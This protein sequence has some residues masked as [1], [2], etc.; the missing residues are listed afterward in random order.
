M[1]TRQ[2]VLVAIDRAT[3]VER[4]TE[5][6]LM[7]AGAPAADVH[8]ISV[9]PDRTAPASERTRGGTWEH[10]DRDAGVEARLASLA[11]S[12]GHDGARIRRVTLHGAP[13]EVIP[14]YARIHDAALLVLERDYGSSPFWRNGR[15][16]DDVARRSPVPLLVLPE[17]GVRDEHWPRR[18]L[19]PV[20]FSIASAMALRRGVELARR[21]GAGV[22]VLHALRDVARH[23]VSSGSEAWDAVR[24]LP[25]QREVVAERLRRKAALFGAVDVRTEVATG[26]APRAIVDTAT[27]SDADLIVMGVA[28]RSWLDR[29]LFGTTLRQV[30][31]RA[32]VPVL[33]VPVLA[34]AHAWPDELAYQVSSGGPT[35]GSIPV[36]P[37]HFSLR[38]AFNL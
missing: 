8:V 24:R 30:L 4:A 19:A 16:V 17:H 14:A 6:A 23:V 37:A 32:T 3:D 34:G 9:A 21:H 28:H 36:R 35:A 33:V 26:A 7:T 2:L 1:A 29:A 15:V 11:R 31:R 20:D 18:I 13:E 5:F 38:G 12:A 27:R 22:T 25:A 10:G